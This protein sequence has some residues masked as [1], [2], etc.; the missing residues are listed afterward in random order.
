[1]EVAIASPEKN[2][3]KKYLNKT[4]LLSTKLLGLFVIMA[5]IL[6]MIVF[7]NIALSFKNNFKENVRP[8]LIQYLEYI[9]SDIGSPPN[10][11]KAK[12]I[13]SRLPVEVTVISQ[14][15][16][17]SSSNEHLDLDSIHYYRESNTKNM[18]YKMGEFNNREYLVF[19]K[20]TQTLI[21]SI[22][23]PHK[24]F[25]IKHVTPI[26]LIL[27]LM[28]IFYYLIRRIFQPIQTIEKGVKLIGQGN[29]HHEIH[30][31]RKDEL[32]SLAKSI[33]GMTADI[34]QMLNAKKQ[35]LL[36][37]SHEIRTPVTRARIAA[38]MLNNEKH[39]DDII[40]DLDEI[41]GLTE[42]ILETERLSS[43][44]KTLNKQPLFIENLLDEVIATH[45]EK[46]NLSQKIDT[47]SLANLDPM[48]IKLLIKNLIKNSIQHNNK[49]GGYPVITVKNK[50]DLLIFS[51]KDYGGGI[52]AEH[53]KH[54][55]EPFYR[56]DPSRKRETGGYG[57]G[58]YLCRIIAEAHGGSLKIISEI[59]SGTEVIVT[60]PR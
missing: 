28:L 24:N 17:W 51:V 42:E 60:L 1:M 37:I 3:M 5:L 11:D 57:L 53:I 27:I 33:N 23:H 50:K 16:N 58:L 52:A 10:I 45:F 59:G 30:V 40:T 4:H 54:L 46:D 15:I 14:T 32:G 48:R 55:T 7:G 6:A 49:T 22:P 25:E 56:V 31:E 29:F 8:H 38:E 41:E 9:Q 34:N 43:R 26:L 20:P 21:F 36:A 19:Q 2:R 12:S 39:K 47:T 44:H 18:H 13:A 35:L